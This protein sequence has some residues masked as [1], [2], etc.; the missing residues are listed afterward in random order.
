[1][2]ERQLLQL[3]LRERANEDGSAAPRRNEFDMRVA[4][5][6]EDRRQITEAARQKAANTTSDFLDTEAATFQRELGSLLE[7]KLRELWP[8]GSFLEG[9]T[10]NFD[11][12][13]KI[14]TAA[15]EFAQ[16]WLNRRHADTEDFLRTKLK[17]EGDRLARLSSDVGRAGAQ[18][19]GCRSL[20]MFPT[21]IP[22]ESPLRRDCSSAIDYRSIGSGPGGPSYAERGFRNGVFGAC[23][24]PCKTTLPNSRTCFGNPCWTG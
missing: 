16:E 17:A 5:I 4:E 23:N 24:K 10:N 12:P 13:S 15:E 20:P 7:A 18:V 6:R 1:V 22:A 2:V 14:D 8:S 11:L 3:R 9:M 21:T 19:F